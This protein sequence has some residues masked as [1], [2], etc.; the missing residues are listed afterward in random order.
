MTRSADFNLYRLVKIRKQL[1]KSAAKT[2]IHSLVIPY[3]DNANVLLA[4]LP[5]TKLKSLQTIQNSA[6]HLILREH[7]LFVEVAKFNLHWLPF[8]Q[9]N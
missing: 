9:K 2:M 6:A 5:M 1:N 3:L 8:F 7:S 4:G